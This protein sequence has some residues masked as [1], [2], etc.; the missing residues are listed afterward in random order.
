M[1]TAPDTTVDVAVIGYGPV[2]ATLA[3]LL[4]QTGLRAMV[5]ERES[6]A[7]HLPRAVSFDDEVMRVFQAIGLADRILP[8]THAVVGTRFID[9]DGRLLIEWPRSLSDGAQGWSGNYRFH[10]PTLERLLRDGVGRF[11]QVSVRTHTEATSLDEHE[12]GVT[13]HATDVTT[14]QQQQVRARYVVGCDGAR[15]FVRRFVGTQ[16][17]DLGLHEH[18]LVIDAILTHDM[19]ELGDWTL[20]YCNPARPAT[21]VRGIG[22]R[23][24]WE[25]MQTPA[26]D[27]ETF[28]DIDNVWRLLRPWITPDDATI[29]RAV[30]YVFHALLARQWR[31]RRLLLAGDA[32]HQ[33]P[34]FLG[35]GMCAGIRDA[36]NLAW[37]LA[38]VVQGR[39]PE[40]LLDTYGSERAPHVR[41]FIELAVRLGGLIMA[42]RPGLANPLQPQ[43]LATL[44]PRLGHGAYDGTVP[45]AGRLAPQPMLTDG[46][47][48]DDA[49]G[50]R[51]ALLLH[52]DAAPVTRDD[53]V[54]VQDEALRPWLNGLG[55]RA[56]VVRPDR[57]LQSIARSDAEVA[58]LS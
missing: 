8:E 50:Y 42:M 32:A 3:N 9:P 36:A 4:G 43:T 12:D 14:G 24:R 13:V 18:W 20:Q 56:A 11:P 28:A 54:V 25:I 47:R 48:L 40:A 5:L 38:A 21:Y 44:R 23:R 57:Y 16:I 39:A 30:V 52:P 6:S 49:V 41:E 53:L 10:Q 34:P 46:R 55:A 51:F 22:M 35:Q 15:S 26:D 37:K 33:T 58:A 2:G 27:A 7:Y 45:A 31:R 17:E 29:E 19:P 1:S